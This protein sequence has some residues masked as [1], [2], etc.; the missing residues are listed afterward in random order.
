MY[1]TSDRLPKPALA[2]FLVG[3]NS[4]GE[5]YGLRVKEVWTQATNGRYGEFIS[6]KTFD[7]PPVLKDMRSDVP[8][9]QHAAELLYWVMNAAVSAFDGVQ[10]MVS[11]DGV[12]GRFGIPLNKTAAFFKDRAFEATVGG[13]RKKIFHYV[14]EHTRMTAS[15]RFT[16]VRAHFRGARRFDWK[17]TSVL[18]T[19]PGHHHFKIEELNIDTESV[20][21]FDAV[22]RGRMT[23]EALGKDLRG[24]MEAPT[25]QSKKLARRRKPPVN[26]RELGIMD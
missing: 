7:Y 16:D 6:H 11:K 17:G 5:A 26:L 14:E 22:P 4:K 23:M 13:S 8:P 19:V 2:E 3:V 10:V 20:S 15:G 24:R 9:R 18:L 1:V 12:S 25:R 21:A